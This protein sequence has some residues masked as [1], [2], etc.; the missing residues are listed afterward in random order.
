MILG[1]RV[2]RTRPRSGLAISDILASAL[3]A[4]LVSP[5][6]QLWLVTGW[7]SDIT[8]IDNSC[9]EFTS[10]L[11]GD[12][13]AM[14]TLSQVLLRLACAGTQVHVAV[15][16]SEH[17]HSFID[18]MKRSEAPNVFTYHGADLHE[19][20]LCGWNWVMTGSMN[21]TWNGLSTNEEAIHYRIDQA[22]AARQRLEL[23]QRWLA[24]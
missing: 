11:R 13:P 19:K 2:V 12:R 17:N 10:V 14:L 1:E 5:G 16:E 18:R 3:I 4:E 6:E 20:I 24:T 21:F 7:V 8:V 15:N 22:W 23:Q 9:D